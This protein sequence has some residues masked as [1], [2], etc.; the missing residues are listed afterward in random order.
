[1]SRQTDTDSKGLQQDTSAE[2]SKGL[3]NP[4]PA[5]SRTTGSSDQVGEDSET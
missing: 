2:S 4:T 3:Q 1:M 5:Q